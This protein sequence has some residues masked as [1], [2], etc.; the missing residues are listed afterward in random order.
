MQ[1]ITYNMLS[2]RYQPFITMFDIIEEEIK[3]ENGINKNEFIP[4]SFSI[5]PYFLIHD[6]MLILELSNWLNSDK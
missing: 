5:S 1:K 2:Y 4:I 3:K 6:K